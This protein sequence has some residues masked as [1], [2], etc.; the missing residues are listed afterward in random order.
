MGMA[1]A[2]GCSLRNFRFLLGLSLEE[3]IEEWPL[4]T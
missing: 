4:P 2:I 1:V 3:E